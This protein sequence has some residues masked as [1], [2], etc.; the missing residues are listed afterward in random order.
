MP[1]VIIGIDKWMRANRATVE[2]MLQAIAEGGDAVKSSEAALARAS[3]VS[4]ECYKENGADAAYWEK[5]YRGAQERD[6]TGQM[7]DLGGS[8]VDNLA[9]MLLT[10]GLVPGSANLYAA[11]YRVFGDIVS[12][13]YPELVPNFPPVQQVLDTSYMQDL[14]RKSAPTPAAI[15]KATPRPSPSQPMR[16]VVSRKEWRI[17]FDTGKASF[18]PAAR[19]QLDQLRSQLLVA[20]GTV[21]EIHGH[22]DSQGNPQANMDLSEKRA[23]AVKSWLEK[24]APVNFPKGRIRVFA[25][26][27]LNPVAPNSTPSGR[28]LNRRVEVV[29]GTTG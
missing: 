28:A 11:T 29:L 15:A 7:V 20:S 19:K 10:F 4:Q 21:V 25:H 16:T 26:G 3:A 2:G 6:K 12:A 17:P 14:S 18:T 9:D 22:T 1:C 23:F 13:Q 5:Y 8:A 27:Q 24:Q